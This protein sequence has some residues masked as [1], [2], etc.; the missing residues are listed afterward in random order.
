VFATVPGGELLGL[1]VHADGTVYAFQTSTA[2]NRVIRLAGDG[3]VEPVLTGIP[4]GPAR[5]GGA[6]VAGPDGMLYVATGDAGNGPAA[7]DP[8]SLAGKVL[9]L[10]P[11]G[12]PAP[13][14]PV[15]DSLVYARGF[16]DPQGLAWY[17]QT[18]L[19]LTD[20]GSTPEGTPDRH[21]ELNLVQANGD[22][23]WPATTSFGGNRTYVNPVAAWQPGEAGFGGLA[24]QG[25]RIYLAG[26]RLYRIWLEGTEPQTMLDGR[27]APMHAIATAPDRSV[28]VAASDSVLRVDADGLP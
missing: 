24:V 8:A 14:N 3:S 26:T 22:Y 4:H 2:D 13:G 7:T 9:R 20:A 15:P 28:W 27:F 17:G 23:G 25:G 10:T 18:D 6:I 16:R 11:D 21:D 19:F 12:T 5:N 1:A